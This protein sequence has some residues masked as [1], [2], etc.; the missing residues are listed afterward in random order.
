M[1]HFAQLDENNVV[2]TVIVVGND[3]IR[4][5]ETGRESEEIGI[6]FCKNHI[7]D[8]NSKWKQTSYNRRIRKH[9]A[10]PGYT[11]NEAIDAFVPPKPFESWILNEETAEWVSPLGPAPELTDEQRITKYYAWN[12]ETAQWNLSDLAT[13]GVDLTQIEN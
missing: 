3:V 12:E 11:Y 13:T 5:P 10:G 9:Y 2:L 4:D 7:N 8:Q 6:Q 1:A